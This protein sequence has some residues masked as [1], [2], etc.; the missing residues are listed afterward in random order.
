[1]KA[2]KIDIELLR[3]QA[4]QV[5]DLLSAYILLHNRIIKNTSS[6][7]SLFKKV[8]FE[9]PY[10]ESKEMLKRCN[11]KKNELYDLKNR[12][13]KTLDKETKTYLGQLLSLAENITKTAQLLV[14]RQK[15][16]YL[17]NRGDGSGWKDFSNIQQEYKRAIKQCMTEKDK[18]NQLNHIIS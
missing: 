17:K 10:E 1:M 11:K 14:K 4:Y 8:D 5:N 13:F 2:K 6:L 12:I 7:K 9:K 15:L 3:E 16:H 18:L